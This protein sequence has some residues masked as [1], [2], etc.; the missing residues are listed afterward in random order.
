M[1]VWIDHCKSPTG[2]FTGEPWLL[3]ETA[4]QFKREGDSVTITWRIWT[5]QCGD[6]ETRSYDIWFQGQDTE[7]EVEIFSYSVHKKMPRPMTR[8]MKTFPKNASIETEELEKFQTIRLKIWNF[9]TKNI[10]KYRVG[11]NIGKSKMA[12]IDEV[13]DGVWSDYSEWSPCSKSCISHSDTTPGEMSR[14]RNCSQPIN[15]GKE[16]DGDDEEV[17]HCAHGPGQS[18][19]IQR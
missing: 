7:E 3:E 1:V 19:T 8:E 2:Y 4:N 16:C 5:A 12:L 6:T 9:S 18:H 13:V 15:G 11:N 10:G 14:R 17:Q